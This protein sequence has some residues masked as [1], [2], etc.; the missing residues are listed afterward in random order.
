MGRRGCVGARGARSPPEESGRDGSALSCPVEAVR[1][2]GTKVLASNKTGDLTKIS[3]R[4]AMGVAV[5]FSQ[6]LWHPGLALAVAEAEGTPG[7]GAISDCT[8]RTQACL[9][10]GEG[11]GRF[12][13]ITVLCYFVTEIPLILD[14]YDMW[15]EAI[16][17]AAE[18]GMRCLLR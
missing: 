9:L 7:S 13:D 4:G 1:R 2:L 5:D 11:L 10:C 17:C 15:Q 18:S 3:K 16:T 12:G 6:M 8:G 14:S